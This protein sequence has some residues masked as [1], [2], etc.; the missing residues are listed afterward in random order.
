MLNIQK[1]GNNMTGHIGSLIKS[2]ASY[3]NVG[4]AFL[5]VRLEMYEDCIVPSLLHGMEAW[6]KMTK[7]E[8][9]GLEKLQAK[10]LCQLLNLPI[11]TPYLALLS[12]VGIMRMEERMTY[13]KS[14]LLHNIKK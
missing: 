9:K 10:A 11:T 14:M 6:N 13:R 8:I 4:D 1:K 2:T 5:Q 12:E 3:T 7:T